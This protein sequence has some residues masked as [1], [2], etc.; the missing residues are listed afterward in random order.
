MLLSIFWLDR[1]TQ[2]GDAV[3]LWRSGLA[4]GVMA[5]LHPYSVASLFTLA[6]V[7]TVARKKMRAIGYL[8]RYFAVSLPF[9]IYPAAVSR[10]NPILAQHSVTGEMKSPL[11]A[12]YALGFGLPLLLFIA[13]LIVL[14]SELLKKYWYLTLWC[15]PV[16][17]I[18][19]FSVLVSAETRFWRSHSVVH[20]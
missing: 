2:H 3:D 5:L 18:R 9:A 4:T 6:V 15:F 10:L 19:L 16:L 7:V 17:D 13:G 8:L 12:G 1:G 14:R 20:H 11:P